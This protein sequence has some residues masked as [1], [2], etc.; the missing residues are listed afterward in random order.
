MY[1]ENYENENIVADEYEGYND[2][3]NNYDNYDEYDYQEQEIEPSFWDKN[4]GLII[5]IAIIV[6]CVIILAWL[7]I[8]LKGNNNE[9]QVVK[10]DGTVYNSNVEAIRLAMEKYFFIDGNLPK[11]G[12]TKSVTLN[13]MNDLNLI[14]NVT[15]YNNKV[16]D[17]TSSYASMSKSED[18]YTLTVNLF[19]ET[20][21]KP[22]AFYYNVSNWAC[23]NCTGY[24]Y[25]D[26]TNY[27]ENDKNESEDNKTQTDNEYIDNLSCTKWSDWTDRK[28]T[29]SNL[30]IKTRILVKGELKGTITNK[31]VYGEW[32]EYTKNKITPSDNLEVEI[33]TKQEPV[34]V[35]KTNSSSVTASDTIRNVTTTT[36]GGGSYYTCPSGY[37][38]EG[39]K[40]YKYV[41]MCGDLTFS[42]VATKNNG[43]C[44]DGWKNTKT[45]INATKKYHST[46]TTYHYEEL[47]TQSVTYYRSRTKT[48]QEVQG[49]STYTDYMLESELPNG[50][51]KVAGSEKTEYSYKLKACEK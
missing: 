8:K 47:V 32:S 35:S 11:D 18:V 16:C 25:M 50:Y 31:V 37:E 19:C 29:N 20:E 24:T 39:K 17:G 46:Q 34:W 13:E 33:I 22:Q 15:D 51:T 49:E 9:D 2:Y 26:G 38:K 45:F 27:V 36:T 10:N 3:D 14:S 28:L 6:L 21:N 43:K 44:E 23:M 1:T 5:K 12:E 41:M 48:I 30:D 7:I 42:E 40:C 4:K